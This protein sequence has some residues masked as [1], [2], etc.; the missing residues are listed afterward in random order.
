MTDFW[1]QEKERLTKALLHRSFGDAEIVTLATLLT[2]PFPELFTASLSKFARSVLIRENPVEVRPSERY[3]PD[4]AVIES[5]LA[6]LKAALIQE[7][8]LRKEEVVLIAEEAISFEID[9]IVRPRQKALE[10]VL[11]SQKDE[12]I[13]T[14]IEA[15]LRGFGEKRR[16]IEGSLNALSNFPGP[17]VSVTELERLLKRVEKETYAEK[18]LST[19]L[20]EIE[21]YQ[22]FQS[23]ALGEAVT[24]I[25]SEILLSIIRDRDLTAML[26]EIGQEARTKKEWLLTEIKNSLQRFILVGR[27][28]QSTEDDL[29]EEAVR[30]T[31]TADKTHQRKDDLETLLFDF[32]EDDE[33]PEEKVR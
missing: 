31:A 27:V 29:S 7:T 33:T 16:F 10:L 17:R 32:L 5:H 11:L 23:R 20:E 28:E 1:Q 30:L 15:I 25:Q 22:Q 18:P 6:A 4:S 9:L 2:T 24:T 12:H 3:S 26:H 14:D 21:L 19:L 13:K 8:K